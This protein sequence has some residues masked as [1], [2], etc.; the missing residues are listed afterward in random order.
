MQ[1]SVHPL[2]AGQP[3]RFAAQLQLG[4]SLLDG[5]ATRP[6]LDQIL[7]RL[8]LLQRRSGALDG[9]GAAAYL[10]QA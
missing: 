4:A 3:K 7:L 6:G 5:L 1:D 9:F 10:A 8:R 2:L